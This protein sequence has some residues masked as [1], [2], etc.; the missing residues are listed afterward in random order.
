MSFSSN[1]FTNLPLVHTQKPGL[2]GTT[3]L[4]LLPR[5]FVNVFTCDSRTRPLT[6]SRLRLSLLRR[7]VHVSARHS[8]T[9][10]PTDSRIGHLPKLAPLPARDSGLP[11]VRESASSPNHDPRISRIR[12]SEASHVPGFRKPWV[13]CPWKTCLKNF[14]KLNVSRV[15]GFSEF[16]NRKKEQ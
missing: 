8:R 3:T 7:F 15:A 1:I 11:H 9:G 13:S 14:V 10:S 4:T 12:E 16:P 2:F 5:W 6:D